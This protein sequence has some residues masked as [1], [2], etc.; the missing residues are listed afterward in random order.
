MDYDIVYTKLRDLFIFQD[1]SES[2][3]EDQ[4]A[5]AS[6]TSASSFGFTAKWFDSFPQPIRCFKLVPP[7][8][9]IATKQSS[10]ASISRAM[11]PF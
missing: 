8:P 11:D 3:E 9:P 4:G 7:P 2:R 6:R 5:N 10:V 1:E